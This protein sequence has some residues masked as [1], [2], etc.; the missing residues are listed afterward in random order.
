MIGGIVDGQTRLHAGK[1]VAAAP[2]RV[3]GTTELIGF[4]H[5][6]G[7]IDDGV[8]AARERQRDVERLRLGARTDRRCRDDFERQTEVEAGKGTSGF[9]V[10]GFEDGGN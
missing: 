10:V 3:E 6:L 8:Q 2:E 4:R 7:V 9:V 5:V 1:S